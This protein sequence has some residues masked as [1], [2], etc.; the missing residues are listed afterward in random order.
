MSAALR[1]DRNEV[2][3][4]LHDRRT[5]S[6]EGVFST[7]LR[8]QR[9]PSKSG[10]TAV[11]PSIRYSVSANILTAGFVHVDGENSGVTVTRYKIPVL[12]RPRVCRARHPRSQ[13]RRGTCAPVLSCCHFFSRVSARRRPF[14]AEIE[15][16]P[17]GGD[18]WI[19]SILRSYGLSD[20][21]RDEGASAGS[22]RRRCGFHIHPRQAHLA[23]TGS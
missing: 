21:G 5:Q 2:I 20:V 17:S 22:V 8:A 9:L 15:Q 4:P 3:A 10:L 16:Q 14:L 7:I 12:V 6:T 11:L 18:V 19:S 23:R 13:T 1:R